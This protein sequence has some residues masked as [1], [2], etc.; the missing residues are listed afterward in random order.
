MKYVA[1]TIALA[2]STIA[3]YFSVLGMMEIF[4][5]YSAEIIALTVLLEMAKITTAVYL[6]QNWEKVSGWTKS[7]LAV[8][9]SILAVITS[10]GVYSFL[11]KSHV[12]QTSKINNGAV[13]ELLLIDIERTTIESEINGLNTRIKLIE[14]GS[15]KKIETAK[16]VRDTEI[17]GT[18]EEAKL[19]ELNKEKSGLVNQLAALEVKK[20]DA[21]IQA[22][23]EATIFGEWWFKT[24]VVLLVLTLDPLALSLLMSATSL[25]VTTSVPQVK[26][27]SKP[28]KKLVPA[29]RKPVTKKKPVAKKAA[30][31]KLSKPKKVVK[32][33]VKSKPKV[34]K[35]KM[36]VP[37]ATA[38]KP[39]KYIK[40]PKSAVIYY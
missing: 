15:D 9:A 31:K 23:A 21:D 12:D 22:N 8:A 17:V 35:R 37:R 3:G 19:K 7:Y 4:P 32:R 33:K 40:L 18:V 5:K 38:R 30:K 34:V 39:K 10:L 16:K 25:E 36:T 26:R 27:I 28:T 24:L 1:I 13:K 14:K 6:H 2:L 29:K 20:L 11:M